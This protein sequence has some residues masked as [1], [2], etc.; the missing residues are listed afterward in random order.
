LGADLVRGGVGQGGKQAKRKTELYLERL[1]DAEDDTQ[2]ALNGS[3]GLTGNELRLVSIQ[4]CV[5]K[6]QLYARS[7]VPRRSPSG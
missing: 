6:G 7:S 1:T 5:T 2:A 3:L 4:I